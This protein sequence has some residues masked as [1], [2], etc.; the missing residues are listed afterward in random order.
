MCSDGRLAA[1]SLPIIYVAHLIF[2]MADNLNYLLSRL[3]RR[4]QY[5]KCP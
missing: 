1:H 3:I 2:L 4:G 5:G